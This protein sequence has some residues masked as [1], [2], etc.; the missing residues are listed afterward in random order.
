MIT[1]DLGRFRRVVVTASESTFIDGSGEA[2]TIGS[3]ATVHVGGDTELER[4]ERR[5]R[6]EDALAATQAAANEGVVPGGGVALIRAAAAVADDFGLPGHAC[7]RRRPGGRPRRR[8]GGG[9]CRRHRHQRRPRRSGHR[10]RHSRGACPTGV[11]ARTGEVADLVA[12]GVVDP[13]RVT[14]AALLNAASIAGLVL[15]TDVLVVDD[16][17]SDPENGDG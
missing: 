13:T 8:G 5:T 15:T 3:L 1:T 14:R 16:G 10:G 11:D 6:A 9:P 4:H 17:A 12:A 7:R 2:D